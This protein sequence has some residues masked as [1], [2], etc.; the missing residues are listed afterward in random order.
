MLSKLLQKLHQFETLIFDMKKFG[1]VGFL[2]WSVRKLG[3]I[4]G[5]PLPQFA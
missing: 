4:A 1:G 5:A 2:V 3:V